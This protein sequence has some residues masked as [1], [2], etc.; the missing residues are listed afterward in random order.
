MNFCGLRP[1]WVEY[2]GAKTQLPTIF[3]CM[4]RHHASTL[5]RAAE[6]RRIADQHY[7]PGNAAKCH[8]QVWRRWIY[9]TY[10][11]DYRTYLAY[12]GMSDAPQNPSDE[13]GGWRQ[14]SLFDDL[15]F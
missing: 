15:D 2:H 14:L 7:E 12:M 9:P 8:K 10:K 4:K 11:I 6:I 5:A 13:I 3:A 1:I